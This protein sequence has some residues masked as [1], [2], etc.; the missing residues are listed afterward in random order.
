MFVK[1][2]IVSMLAF[3]LVSASV[4]RAVDHEQYK[5]TA[6]DAAS[7]DYFGYSVAISG[8]LAIVGAHRDDDTSNGSGSAYVFRREGANWVEE[9]KLTA[10]D[11]ASYRWRSAT[12]SS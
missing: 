7:Y 8:N 12:T 5:L 10:S 6:S 1:S 4:A 2:A 9:V 3:I 11:A